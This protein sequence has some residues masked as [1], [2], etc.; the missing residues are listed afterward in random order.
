MV[1]RSL[2]GS[3][4]AAALN[5]NVVFLAVC[6]LCEN[7]QHEIVIQQIR[8]SYLRLDVQHLDVVASEHNPEHLFRQLGPVVEN[9]GK[10]SVV[11]EPER[12]DPAGVIGTDNVV[13]FSYLPPGEFPFTFTYI[14]PQFKRVCNKEKRMFFHP[15]FLCLLFCHASSRR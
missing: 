5:F 9:G 10:K 14:I 15:L 7:I 2:R 8:D 1:L 3:A 13:F 4:C 12:F 11:K 6:V